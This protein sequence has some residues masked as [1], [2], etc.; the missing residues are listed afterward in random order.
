MNRW[1][2]FFF[3]FRAFSRSDWDARTC[4]R[5]VLHHAAPYLRDQRQIVMS[6]DDTGLPKRSRMIKACSWLRDSLGAPHHCHAHALLKLAAMKAF[7]PTRTDD[8]HELPPW[9]SHRDR[10]GLRKP[11]ANDLLTRLRA[12]LAAQVHAKPPDGALH[13]RETFAAA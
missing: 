2:S 8:Y 9:R 6:L 1:I 13:P 4:F 11:S 5:G 12:D 7:G 10:E 3:D